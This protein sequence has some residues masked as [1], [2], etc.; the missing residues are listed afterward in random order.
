MDARARLFYGGY[1]D[2]FDLRFT[3]IYILH[4]WRYATHSLTRKEADK[5]LYD[6]LRAAGMDYLKAKSIYEAVRCFGRKPLVIW[7]DIHSM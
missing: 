6:G 5:E 2:A 1:C 4:D 3:K 7:N